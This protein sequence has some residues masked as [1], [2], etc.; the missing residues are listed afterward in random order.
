MSY[1]VSSW[2]LTCKKKRIPY[3]RFLLVYEPV[4]CSE[5]FKFCLNLVWLVRESGVSLFLSLV[6]TLQ[7]SFGM[8]IY[9]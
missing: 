1:G 6:L 8:L 5:L 7:E 2:C 4:I 3:M 9:F